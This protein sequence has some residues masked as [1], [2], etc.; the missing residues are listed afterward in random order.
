MV[1]DFGYPILYRGIMKG[2][3]RGHQIGQFSRDTPHRDDEK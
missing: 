3:I 2:I 1:V